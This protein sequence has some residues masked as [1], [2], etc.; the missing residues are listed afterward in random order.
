MNKKL[1]LGAIAQLR[2][3]NPPRAVDSSFVCVTLGPASLEGI[4]KPCGIWNPGRKG[5]IA[6]SRWLATV[7]TETAVGQPVS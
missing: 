6:H 3:G 1:L 4:P 5:S 2:L 7:A